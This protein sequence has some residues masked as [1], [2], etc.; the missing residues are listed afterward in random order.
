LIVYTILFFINVFQHAED[1]PA[2]WSDLKP[3]FHIL[4]IDNGHI[5]HNKAMQ[6]WFK[7]R[8]QAKKQK[9]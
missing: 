6:E 9:K 8:E 2:E 3:V 7:L 5:D 1:H 4:G